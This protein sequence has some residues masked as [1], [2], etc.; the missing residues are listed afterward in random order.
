MIAVIADDITGAAEMSGIARHLG[1]S[2]SLST[3]AGNA[4]EP[5]DVLVIATDT[6]S[7]TEAE[8]TG[9]SA[10]T[11][12]A[13]AANPDVSHIFKK[14]DSVLRGHVVAELRAILDNTRYS[15]A[16]YLPANP[17]KGRFI[18]NG[19]YL[20]GDTEL[21][22][23]DFARDPEF[24]AWTSDVKERLQPGDPRIRTADAMTS[25]D[26]ISALESASDA[27]LLAG[28]ADLFTAFLGK[29]GPQ[30]SPVDDR[31][32]I[33]IKNALIVC[34]STQSKPIG[35][36][37]RTEHLPLNVYDGESG[38]GEWIGK[39]TPG[40]QR[41]GS[42]ILDIPHHHLTGRDV[43][44]RLRTVMAETVK[45]LI[46]A[47][48]PHELIIEG[49]ATAFAI[50]DALGWK[51][52]KVTDMIAPGVIRMLSDDSGAYVTMKPGSYPW[53]SLFDDKAHSQA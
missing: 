15:E 14:T 33:D 39:I 4:G 23:T 46:D 38:A 35:C 11:A 52:F 3:V 6:R 22:L 30:G 53:G 10:E 20:I 48:M 19:R 43:A 36:G 5:V 40:Y 27:T 45:R 18:R 8:A 32:A 47:K 29:T 50:L 41:E 42:L 1:L 9:V 49:G 21:H 26:I 28:A 17:S 51:R 37:I 13:L 7:M 25:A 31:P 44:V 24:P 12:R 16:L 2:V 34:G